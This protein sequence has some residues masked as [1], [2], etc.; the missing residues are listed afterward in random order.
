MTKET[1]ERLYGKP[2]NIDAV[3]EDRD[4]LHDLTKDIPPTHLKHTPVVSRALRNYCIAAAIGTC[5][6]VIYAFT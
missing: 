2:A 4:E 1:H 5:L 3:W 6:L